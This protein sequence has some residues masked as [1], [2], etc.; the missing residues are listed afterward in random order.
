MSI[1]RLSTL[2][3]IVVLLTGVSVAFYVEALRAAPV[4][5][6][7]PPADGGY[8]LWTEQLPDD[9][10]RSGS[11]VHGLRHRSQA[12]LGLGEPSGAVGTCCESLPPAEG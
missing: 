7:S 11:P 5:A 6:G 9:V 10:R 1:R 12:P 8:A 3:L 2:V 4:E